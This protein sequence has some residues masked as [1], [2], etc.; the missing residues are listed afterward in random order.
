[1]Q[2][3][4]AP[5]RATQAFAKL[6]KDMK[7]VKDIVNY[8]KSKKNFTNAEKESMGDLAKNEILKNAKNFKDAKGNKLEFSHNDEIWSQLGLPSELHTMKGAEFFD[9]LKVM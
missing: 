4:S 7:T 2:V 5:L 6:P 9:F 3:L 1:M 8:T